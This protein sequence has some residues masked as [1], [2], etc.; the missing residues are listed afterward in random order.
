MG[1]FK[2][3]PCGWYYFSKLEDT[4]TLYTFAILLWPFTTWTLMPLKTS[5]LRS[6]SLCYAYCY[7]FSVFIPIMLYRLP[8][9][10]IRNY[11]IEPASPVTILGSIPPIVMHAWF[12]YTAIFGTSWHIFFNPIFLP[13]LALGLYGV[14]PSVKRV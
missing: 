13:T 6:D 5:I 7:M 12:I 9:L 14:L 1:Q 4:R 3:F 11:W 2:K 10:W 8:F